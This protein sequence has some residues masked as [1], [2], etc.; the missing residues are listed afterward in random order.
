MARRKA[1]QQLQSELES[2]EE[3]EEM[4]G[5]EGLTGQWMLTGKL[6]HIVVGKVEKQ[7]LPGIYYLEFSE[8][9][10]RQE[11]YQHVTAVV[12]SY[13]EQHILLHIHV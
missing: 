1:E 12:N 10:Q 3:F 2:T 13:T 5:R 9:I 11:Q 6:C 7:A 8:S 4:L